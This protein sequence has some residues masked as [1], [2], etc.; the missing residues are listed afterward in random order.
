MLKP[1]LCQE[2]TVNGYREYGMDEAKVTAAYRKAIVEELERMRLRG[3]VAERK[4]RLIASAN[5]TEP[6]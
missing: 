6:E 5:G 2:I 4:R 1:M 3:F